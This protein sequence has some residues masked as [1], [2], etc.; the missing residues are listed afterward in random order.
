MSEI[1]QLEEK[2]RKLEK[3]V[4]A[5]EKKLEEVADM[6][7]SADRKAGDVE[8]DLEYITGVVNSL[9]PEEEEGEEEK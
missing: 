8:D 5:I 2:I 7:D 4:K 6:A 1:E 9:I 3:R